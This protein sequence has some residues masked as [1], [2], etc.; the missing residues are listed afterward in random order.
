MPVRSGPPAGRRTASLAPDYFDALYAREPDPWR[1]ASSEYEAAKYARTLAA[2][3]DRPVGRAWEVGCSIGIFTRQLATRCG[4]VLAV[5]VAAAALR[6]AAGNCAGC[7]N[8]SFERLQIPADWPPG[9][10]DLIVF[11]EVLYYLTE[12][13]IAEIGRRMAATLA[14]GGQIVLV[15]WTGPTD[16][17]CS[18]D[19]AAETFCASVG[20]ELPVIRNE[21]HA[22]YRIDVLAA[23]D[24]GAG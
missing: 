12:Q 17:P 22:L 14:P 24:G 7:A 9:Q 13:D 19:R 11:S 1:F 8:V 21:R 18:G 16:Y 23:P 10:F 5:D 15:H 2:I 3:G 6:Q 20:A 4:A